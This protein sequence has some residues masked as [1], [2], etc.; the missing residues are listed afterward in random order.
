LWGAGLAAVGGVLGDQDAPDGE[1]TVA[2]ARAYRDAIASRGGAEVG[3][4]TMVDAIV[5]C[6]TALERE[7]AAGTGLAQA[8]RAAASE[9]EAAATATA[10]IVARV[11]R[12]RTH[13]ARSLG[14]PDA[15]AVSFAMVVTRLGDAV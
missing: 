11:G 7:V 2:A 10:D 5:P 6:V 1:T 4:K 12:A 15:G 8:W 9:A 3:D 13:G 14:T